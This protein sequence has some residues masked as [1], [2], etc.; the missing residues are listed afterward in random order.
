MDLAQESGLAKLAARASADRDFAVTLSV[1][2]LPTL[3]SV[4]WLSN[5]ERQ[6]LMRL[7]APTPGAPFTSV[8]AS[9]PHGAAVGRPAVRSSLLDAAIRKV[10]EKARTCANFAH[11]VSVSPVHAVKLATFLTLEEKAVLAQTALTWAP[12]I[13]TIQYPQTPMGSAQ[14]Y[15]GA[16]PVIGELDWFYVGPNLAESMAQN[17][18]SSGAYGFALNINRRGVP[19]PRCE[20]IFGFAQGR[21]PWN[22]ETRMD[23]GSVSKFVTA[24]AIVQLL[25]KHE[26]SPESPISPWLPAYWHQGKNVDKISFGDL[27]IH[28]SGMACAARSVGP[29]GRDSLFGDDSFFIRVRRAIE[30]DFFDP[31]F[32]ASQNPSAYRC[33][34]NEGYVL[35]RVLVASLFDPDFIEAGGNLVNVATGGDD[36]YDRQSIGLYQSYVNGYVLGPSGVAASDFAQTYD[37]ASAWAYPNRRPGH[38]L[39]VGRPTFDTSESAGAGGW[40]LSVNELLRLANGFRRGGLLPPAA[41]NVGLSPASVLASL[42]GID[43]ARAFGDTSTN[44][45]GDYVY[46][47]KQGGFSQDGG[48]T[49]VNAV[50]WFFPDDVEMV[51]LVNSDYDPRGIVDSLF[52]TVLL[53]SEPTVCPPQGEC[54]CGFQVASNSETGAHSFGAASIG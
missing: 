39:P 22:L 42:F 48:V 47:S 33:Y 45:G 21:Q 12:R 49:N 4:P 52:A 18:I 51:M 28:E 43:W 50:I 41:A 1:A 7:P 16:V 6:A 35:L 54:P 37:R 40:H 36:W 38:A 2:W 34:S 30:S 17:A 27:L 26:L 53:Q 11:H 20:K 13:L 29:S 9:D 32:M 25:I 10:A 44:C 31:Y 23:V 8:D 14:P 24:I 15:S 46:Y 3:R 19:V 5:E